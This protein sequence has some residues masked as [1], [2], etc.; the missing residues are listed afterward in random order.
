[1]IPVFLLFVFGLALPLSLMLATV[2]GNILREIA[3]AGV[4][5]VFVVAA[6]ALYVRR[7][8]HRDDRRMKRP[9]PA[10]V[11]KLKFPPNLPPVEFEAYCADYLRL[12]GWQVVHSQSNEAHG[13]YLD[14]SR[15]GARVLLQCEIRGE[16]LN[17]TG[18]RTLAL[19]AT[20]FTGARPALVIKGRMV[21]PA[22]HA[23][24][25]AGVAVLQVTDL[26][27]LEALAALPEP[28]VATPPPP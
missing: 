2:H 21:P 11:A 23:A 15:P 7:L 22:A 26:P 18:I 10:A 20:S 24:T 28:A 3:V 19:V 9:N 13:T 16:V 27:R 14:V 12:Q 6:V 8:P 5:L 1:M 25:A 17:P 4:A